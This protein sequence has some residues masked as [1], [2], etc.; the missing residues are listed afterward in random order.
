M[1]VDIGG[2]SLVSNI[3]GANATVTIPSAGTV[4]MGVIAFPIAIRLEWM[5]YRKRAICE[6]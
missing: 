3:T 6:G 5:I 2:L 1:N 4:G